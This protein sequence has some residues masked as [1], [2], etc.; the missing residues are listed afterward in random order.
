MISLSAKP[1]ALADDLMLIT[2]G[3]NALA[4]FHKAFTITLDHLQDMGGNIAGKAVGGAA[5]KD[6]ANTSNIAGMAASGNVKGAE[7]AGITQG[8]QAASSA[9]PGAGGKLIK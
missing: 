6:I 4:T 3:S 7:T 2:T 1:R 9:V 8:T 5:G